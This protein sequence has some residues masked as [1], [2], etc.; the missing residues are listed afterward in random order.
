MLIAHRKH[1][2]IQQQL[3]EWPLAYLFFHIHCPSFLSLQQ[4]PTNKQLRE[5]LVKSRHHEGLAKRAP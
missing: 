3:S 4:M 2:N 5:S 1:E